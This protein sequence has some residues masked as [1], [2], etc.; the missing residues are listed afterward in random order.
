MR[1]TKSRW[2]FD[3]N[4]NVT[5]VIKQLQLRFLPNRVVIKKPIESVMEVKFLER[6]KVDRKLYRYLA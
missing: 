2:V 1:I 6:D 3:H 5:K 4:N